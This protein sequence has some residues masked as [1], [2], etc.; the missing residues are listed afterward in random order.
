MKR[1]ER[2]KKLKPE[3]F[4]RLTGVKPHTFEA[5]LVECEIANKKKKSRGGK[6]NKLSISTQIL[7]MLEYYIEPK[8]LVKS[9]F[10]LTLREHKGYCKF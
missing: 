3:L 5:M 8:L 7:L 9:Q 6:P 4:K 2:L 10:L 1:Y